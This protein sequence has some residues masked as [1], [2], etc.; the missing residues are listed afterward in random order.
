M[1]VDSSRC[2]E[3]H[4]TFLT[5]PG[6]AQE[7]T[8]DGPVSGLQREKKTKAKPEGMRV[9]CLHQLCKNTLRPGTFRAFSPRGPEPSTV[10]PFSREPY[11]GR[12]EGGG[13]LEKGIP[14]REKYN[15]SQGK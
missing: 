4:E 12:G 6:G 11:G 13:V 8:G 3:K 9:P 15:P 7:Q 2:W 5:T 14:G 10:W 1:P